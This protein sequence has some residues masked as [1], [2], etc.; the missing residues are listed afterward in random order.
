MKHE[1]PCLLTGLRASVADCP[2]RIGA[3]HEAS[4]A[5]DGEVKVISLEAPSTMTP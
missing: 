1:K 3:A 4:V 2:R 5:R